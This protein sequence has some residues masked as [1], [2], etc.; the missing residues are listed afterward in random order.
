[1]PDWT[2]SMERTYEFYVV[3]P[4]T[5]K[6]IKQIRTIT[7]CTISRDSEAE[8]LGSA[9]INITES[10][11]ECY[12][13]VYLVTVQNGLKEKHSLGTFL[14]QTP[15][16]SFD[17]KLFDVTMD[18][19]TPLIELKENPPELGYYIKKDENIL[20]WAG[21]L[22]REHMR[23]P[24]IL[25]SSDKKIDKDFVADPNDTWLT[26]L[27]DLLALANYS[28]G[29]DESS[30]ILFVPKRD[31]ASLQPISRFDYKSRSIRRTECSRSCIHYRLWS[32]TSCCTQQRS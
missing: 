21:S 11:G 29:L 32:D 13:R 24:V 8:T 23:A 9:T 10:F 5:W 14:V 4:I 26:Y 22:S 12:I 19:Y 17:G 16:S 3:D 18:A 1:M 31:T 20:N 2:K 25:G 7:S 27:T 30:R 6:D 15:S 28:F